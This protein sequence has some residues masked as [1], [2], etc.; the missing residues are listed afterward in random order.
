MS[1]RFSYQEC[2][3]DHLSLQVG[4]SDLCFDLGIAIFSKSTAHGHFLEDLASE[5]FNIVNNVP[6]VP[7]SPFRSKLAQ[8]VIIIAPL[9][10]PA[11]QHV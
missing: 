3:P 5:L 8:C 10:L 2:S 7:Q 11:T 9:M 4:F 6:K 1:R